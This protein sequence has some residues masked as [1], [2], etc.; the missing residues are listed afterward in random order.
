MSVSGIEELEHKLKRC[1]IQ[2]SNRRY[3]LES[4]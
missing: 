1:Q 4:R 2:I 3:L